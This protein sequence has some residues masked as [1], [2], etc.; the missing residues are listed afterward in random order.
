MTSTDKAPSLRGPGEP[1][2]N[3]YKTFIEDLT[4]VTDTSGLCMPVGCRKFGSLSASKQGNDL[5]LLK[6]DTPHPDMGRVAHHS[7]ESVGNHFSETRVNPDEHDGKPIPSHS[8]NDP[9][10]PISA[11]FRKE[12]DCRKLEGGRYTYV[13]RDESL[14]SD[15]GGNVVPATNFQNRIIQTM[16]FADEEINDEAG[17]RKL[18]ATICH[19]KVSVIMLHTSARTKDVPM[20]IEAITFGGNNVSNKMIG[21]RRETFKM[22]SR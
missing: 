20:V 18:R 5:V 2:T 16:M 7:L 22:T 6:P 15:G 11:Y 19:M 4:R 17:N 9:E 12:E 21:W 13:F 8:W 14:S 3:K 1:Q 10:P